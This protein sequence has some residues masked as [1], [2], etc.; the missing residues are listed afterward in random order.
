VDKSRTP[1]VGAGLPDPHEVIC[2]EA[3]RI[4]DF[5]VQEQHIERTFDAVL[6]TVPKHDKHDR[7]DKKD[8]HDLL[9]HADC[10]I[11][12]RNIRCREV[13]RRT[14][15]DGKKVTKELI[16]LAIEVPV[17]IRVYNH[18]GKVIRV[19]EEKVVFLKQAVLCAPS[20]TDVECRVTGDCCC[21]FDAKKCVISCIFD[22]CVVIQ[23]QIIVRVLV[24]TLG[25]CPAKRC[26]STVLGCPPEVPK[27]CK[28]CDC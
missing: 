15:D 20:G 9:Q 22:F 5:C 21:Y 4:C 6:P 11:D 23:T 14:V 10:E 25:E 19:I 8:D 18:S 26:V 2:I 13:S 24:P 28:H 3:K 1:S 7:C 12:E 17:F 16:C 27:E